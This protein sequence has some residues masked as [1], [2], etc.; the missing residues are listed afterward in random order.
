MNKMIILLSVLSLGFCS[1]S[2]YRKDEDS[3]ELQ[4]MSRDVLND[5]KVEG[6]EIIIKKFGENKENQSNLKSLP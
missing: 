2:L 6:I 5:K 1:C 3:H 4:Q